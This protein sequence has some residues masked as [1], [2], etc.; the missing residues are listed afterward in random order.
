MELVDRC[1]PVSAI[2]I[3]YLRYVLACFDGNKAR[4]AQQIKIDRR[5]IQRWLGRKRR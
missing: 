3:A 1:A 4:A 2:E 5:T